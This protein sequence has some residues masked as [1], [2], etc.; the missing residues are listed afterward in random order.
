MM[1]RESKDMEIRCNPPGVKTA[2]KWKAETGDIK[3]S[4]TISLS[5]IWW[6]QR[7]VIGRDLVLAQIGLHCLQ[8]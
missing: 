1:L 8:V 5:E 2:S 6:V 3:S 4:L 7:K